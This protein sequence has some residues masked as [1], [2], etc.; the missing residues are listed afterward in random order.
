MYELVWINPPSPGG[1][2]HI[3]LGF[4]QRYKSWKYAEN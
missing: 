1:K 3:Q 4:I 2:E